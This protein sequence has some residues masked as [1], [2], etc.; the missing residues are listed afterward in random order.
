ATGNL[1]GYLQEHPESKLADVA[2]TL[3]VGRRRFDHRRLL[4]CQNR[5]E[6]LTALE[7]GD[8]HHIWTT[9]QTERERP[10]AFLLPGVGEQYAGMAQELYEQEKLFRETVD[11]CCSL[12][13]RRLGLELPTLLFPKT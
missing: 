7:T 3:Q 1:A 9:Y 8:P 5:E 4:A 12:L 6:A 13:Q 2:Y 10:V 11:S